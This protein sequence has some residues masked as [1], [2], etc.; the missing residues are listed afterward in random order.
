ML[1]GEWPHELGFAA[2]RHYLSTRFSGLI[3]TRLR[4]ETALQT[5]PQG[6]E[7]KHIGGRPELDPSGFGDRSDLRQ[8]RRGGAYMNC[9]KSSVHSLNE[10]PGAASSR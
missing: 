7:F 6:I 10:G 5:I 2:F 1:E 4:Q 8:L 9:E 3:L